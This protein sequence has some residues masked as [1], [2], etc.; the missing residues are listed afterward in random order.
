[1]S[2]QPTP[3]IT[4]NQIQKLPVPPVN[5]EISNLKVAGKVADQS[6]YIVA[7]N[8]SFDLSIDLKFSGGSLADLLVCVGLDIEVTYA[9]EG[10]GP[11]SEVNL[12]APAIKTQKGQWE[13]TIPYSGTAAMAG[14]TPGFYKVAALV[15][16][17]C[18]KDCCGEPLAFGY[19]SPVV[20]Q[21]YA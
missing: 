4:D 11:A 21:V 5:M 9:L 7:A 20:F 6:Q 16:V 1:M 10:F 14:L 3:Q 8:E 13:Y 15:T 18:P 17:K 2:N 12:T 19:I